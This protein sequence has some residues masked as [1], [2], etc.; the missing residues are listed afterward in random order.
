MDASRKFK[1]SLLD[2]FDF[3]CQRLSPLFC[4]LLF[5]FYFHES[6]EPVRHPRFGPTHVRNSIRI[7]ATTLI[8]KVAVRRAKTGDGPLGNLVRERHR[9]GYAAGQLDQRHYRRARRMGIRWIKTI[10]IILW[11]TIAE[12][13]T[14][15][16]EFISSDQSLG[17]LFAR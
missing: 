12:E 1:R 7:K 13:K 2:V 8:I 9:P 17:K 14:L 15:P 6:G 3:L 16:P 4:L 10:W 11:P 5:T